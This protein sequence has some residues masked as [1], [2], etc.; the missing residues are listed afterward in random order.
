[1]IKNQLEKYDK[2]EPIQIGDLISYFP[3]SDKVTRAVK[4]HFKEHNYVI[5]ICTDIKDDKISF[6]NNGIVD[7][8]VKGIIC[9]GD[10]LTV[11]EEFGKAVAI[12]YAQDETKFKIRQIGKV[13]GLYNDYNKAKVLLDIE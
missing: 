7:V 11:S 8:N 12:K 10:H 9:I 2:D 3:Q 13:I 1:M 6:C 4:R 5:G